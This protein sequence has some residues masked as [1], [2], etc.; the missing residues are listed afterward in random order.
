[1]PEL[2]D[3]PERFTRAWNALSPQQKD[4]EYQQNP[5]IGNHP[6]MP[7]DDRTMCNER[8]LG[9]LTRE[10]QA[11]VN[12]MQARYDQLARQQ[13][14][15]DHSAAVGSELAALGPKLQAAKHSLDEYRGVQNAMKAPPGTPKRY[16][17]LLDDEGQ[18]AVSIGNP[19]TA[20]R[21]AILVPGTGDD[22]TNMTGNTNRAAAMYDAAMQANPNLHAGDV[23]VT[24]WLGYDRPMSVVD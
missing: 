17:G 13:Y 5:F 19:D 24:A 8:H 7:F 4:A 23:S 12:A 2:P 14:M 3:D 18:G 16:L 15:G 9:E 21:N 10:T 20:I 1:M 22:L 6:G 11:D